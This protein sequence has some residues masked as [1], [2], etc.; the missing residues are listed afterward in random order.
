MSSFAIWRDEVY[1]AT[2]ASLRYNVTTDGGII[3]SGRAKA[4]PDG[5]VH[6]NLRRVVKDWLENRLTDFLPMHPD[7]V[8]HPEAMRVFYLMNADTGSVLGTYT[9]LFDWRGDWNGSDQ[10]LSKPVNGH[11]DVRQKL[12]CSFVSDRNGGSNVDF[13]TEDLYWFDAEDYVTVAWNRTE[14]HVPVS[15]NYR[16]DD[17]GVILPQGVTLVSKGRD[18]FVFLVPE[19]EDHDNNVVY[20]VQ[21]TLNGTVVDSTEI[22]VLANGDYFWCTPSLSVDY[23]GGP[24]RIDI[25]TG[26]DMSRLTAS[27][28]A[29]L[30]LDSFTA[31]EAEITVAYNEQRATVT[32]TVNFYLDG[33]TLVGTCTITQGMSSWFIAPQFLWMD[34]QGGTLVIPIDTSYDMTAVSVV[35]PQGITLV[36][37]DQN[38]VTVLVEP[39]NSD[40][41]NRDYTINYTL[42]GSLLGS[43]QVRV[44]GVLFDDYLTVVPAS[45]RVTLQVDGATSGFSITVEY[46]VSNGPWTSR[47]L[48]GA[49]DSYDI[50]G[51]TQADTVRLRGTE[52]RWRFFSVQNISRTWG[53]ILSLIY[54]ENYRSGSGDLSSLQWGTFTKLFAGNQYLTDATGLYLSPKRLSAQCYSGMFED[55]IAI[56]GAPMIPDP[57]SA[58]SLSYYYMFARCTALVDPPANIPSVLADSDCYYM[59]QGCTSLVRTP[60]FLAT[61]L[62]DR[63]YENMFDGC[64]SLTQVTELRATT[65]KRYCYYRMF[66]GCSSLE[67]APYLPA[68]SASYQTANDCYGEMFYGCSSLK[69]I[70]CM[71][72]PASQSYP[73][74][75]FT[76][77]WVYN[78][79]N[80]GTF[81]KARG[82]NW[83]PWQSIYADSGIPSG[84]T[85]QEV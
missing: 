63:C 30:T 75:A 72:N 5:K 11:A 76:G 64:T 50:T 58:T 51:L 13:D 29:G 15:T 69:Y 20:T 52:N 47:T 78:V 77:G 34:S 23:N 57:V 59:F 24:L 41:Q 53:N 21:Y 61:T 70:K 74:P 31:T 25:L 17:I 40:T 46:S 62:A 83:S 45:D 49:T 54:G 48:T 55:C 6:I 3:F 8:A 19:N 60:Y 85:V 42:G 43:T 7:I 33:S 56:T 22:T 18:E 12:F 1:S 79:A 82:V 67:I 14:V 26:Y 2:V 36:S 66:I 73:G 10:M 27:V 32:H 35:L 4:G 81:V 16:L 39:N 84:W 9:V 28:S 80:A 38:S 71:L 44:T 68:R 65:M 37:K